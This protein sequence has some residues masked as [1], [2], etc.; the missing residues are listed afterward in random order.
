MRWRTDCIT[1]LLRSLAVFRKLFHAQSPRRIRLLL[2]PLVSALT[3]WLMMVAA[4][5]AQQSADLNELSTTEP[6][7]PREGDWLEHSDELLQHRLPPTDDSLLQLEEPRRDLA[8]RGGPGDGKRSP[9]TAQLLW[10]PSQ[11]VKGQGT[12]FTLTSEEINLAFPLSINEDGIWLGMTNL[13]RLEI[14]TSAVFPDSSLPVPDQLW[15]IE[16]GV[17]HIR[18]FGDGKKGGAMLRVGSP[19]DQPFAAIRDMTV[20]MLGFLTIPHGD[21]N[22]W[23]L[24]LFYSPTGQ[25]IYPLP[26]I[27][28]IWRP[29]DE[30]TANL[31]IPFSIDYRPSPGRSLTISYMPLT[32][33]QMIASQ[34]IGEPWSIYAGYRAVNETFLLADRIENRQRLYLFDQRLSLGLQRKLVRGWSVD[35]SAAYV[36]DRQIFQAQSFSAERSDQ[37]SITPGVA[38]A[39]QLLWAR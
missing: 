39:I 34:S 10:M 15:D 14:G 21:R 31:G 11:N 24:S 4:G 16:F 1:C 27:A 5:V 9:F 26:G 36:F 33:A 32:N 35:V 38:G 2:A 13:Q 12:D 28:Y 6:P 25:I 20:S 23:S 8:V 19:S 18:E 22:A 3:I 30:F 17:M 7:P 29:T 37:L